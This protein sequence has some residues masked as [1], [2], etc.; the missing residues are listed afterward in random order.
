MMTDMEGRCDN[1]T[2]DS[3]AGTSPRCDMEWDIGSVEG[4]DM[5]TSE[6]GSVGRSQQGDG[7]KVEMRRSGIV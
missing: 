4:R 6:S 7:R 5:N 3:I 2:T 1:V